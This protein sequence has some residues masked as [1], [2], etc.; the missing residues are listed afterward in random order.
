MGKSVVTNRGE[1][2]RHYFPLSKK[3]NWILYR[4]LTAVDNPV[5]LMTTPLSVVT[6]T[7][8]NVE[9]ATIFAV[10]L[11]GVHGSTDV[12]YK[13]VGWD[14]SQTNGE[15]LKEGTL[16]VSDET[17]VVSSTTLYVS[18]SARCDVF[19][20]A[21]IQVYAAAVTNI[22]TSGNTGFLDTAIC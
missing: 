8:V 10:R 20:N 14:K 15:V 3:N 19:H 21:F 17:V 9:L 18:S 5:V 12:T 4:T 1:M 13:I 11:R 2:A 6:T 7:P 16:T 22:D